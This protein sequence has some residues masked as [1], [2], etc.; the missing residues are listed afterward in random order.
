[1]KTNS[2][3]HFL[4][5][6]RFNAI[7]AIRSWLKQA[8]R[9]AALPLIV[10]VF[11]LILTSCSN[12]K[13]LGKDEK[14]YT[15]SWFSQKGFGKIKDKPLK[16][17]EVYSIGKVKTNRPFM[18]MPR[19]SLLIHNYWEPTGTR[20]PRHY[21]YRVFGKPPVLLENVN[22]E[23]RAKVMQQRLYEMGHFDSNVNVNIKTYGKDD[24]KA[25]A[26]YNIIF[27]PAFTFRDYN[28]IPQSSQVDSLITGSMDKALIKPGKW[29]WVNTLEDERS[30]ISNLLREN[31]YYFFN[32]NYLFFHADTTNAHKRV[33]LRLVL[34]SD[35]PNRSL[36]KYAIRNVNVKVNADNP[37][38]LGQN[39]KEPFVY[40]NI[41]FDDPW[42]LFK[43]KRIA[44]GVSVAPGKQ[45]SLTDQMNTVR[46]LQGYDVFKSVNISFNRVDSVA[47][48]LDAVV[49]LIPLKPVQ[50]SLNATFATK[51]NDF[52]GPAAEF[53]IGNMNLFGG[54]E[55]LIFKVN[56]GFEWQK[57]SKRQQYELGFNSYEIGSQLRLVT[58]R[59]LVPFPTRRKSMRYISKTHLTFGYN[60][61]KRVQFYTT[62]VL[63]FKFGYYWR[64]DEKHEYSLDLVS[65]DYLR[66]PKKS[67]EFKLFLDYFSQIANSFEQQ[68]IPGSIFS[69]TFSSRPTQKIGDKLYLN[70]TIDIAGNLASLFSK[71]NGKATDK[72]FQPGLVFGTPYAHYFIWNA[73]IRYFMYM[74]KKKQLATR[75][76]A[77]LGAPYGN[78]SVLPFTKQYY[79]GGS[80]DIRA[81]Y[82][83]SIGPGSYTPAK[84]NVYQGGFIDQTGDIK[85]LANFEFRFPL[86]YRTN[87]AL[88]IDAGNVWLW[89]TDEKRPG[90]EF[91][92]NKFMK[93]LA[94]GTGFGLRFDLEYFIFR[95]DAAIPLRKPYFPHGDN[96]SFNNSGFLGDY[97]LSIA[98]GYP[99]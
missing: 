97:I 86:T 39:K 14:L 17:Y 43:A 98:V 93:D 50:T 58:P 38:Y 63:Q 21:I 57:R 52:L 94:V 3:Y 4:R 27:Y 51:S 71:G 37:K 95:L 77:G 80:Q 72:D 46:F 28:F 65:L 85:L 62:D 23:F 69:Y 18:G 73:D 49:E 31:G 22:P 74:S 47:N 24:K 10:L 75:F 64:L 67:T 30:R 81:F 99:F 9:N 91:R 70:T 61:I 89:N 32:P 83:R 2:T 16:A 8:A 56:G 59:V 20:G 19:T 87:G 15:Y 82:A 42:N 6:L 88:F 33:D 92:F 84:N 45:Y 7:W 25:R 60:S 40:K 48:L 76:F 44:R 68:L 66:V 11:L 79:A 90:G 12:T 34:K 35:I 53:T 13:F 36:H 41:L 29:Y 5:L 26:K 54:A 96:W 78:S 55:K 1:L